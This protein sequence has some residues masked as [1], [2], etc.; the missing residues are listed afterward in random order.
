MYLNRIK[1]KLFPS[2][3]VFI[4]NHSVFFSPLPVSFICKYKAWGF[5]FPPFLGN[6]FVYFICLQCA[7][8]CGGYPLLSNGILY[9]DQCL[10]YLLL[11]FFFINAIYALLPNSSPIIFFHNKDNK[12]I[13]KTNLSF[14]L[15]FCRSTLCTNTGI[16]FSVH[17]P[18][19]CVC[20]MFTS[21]H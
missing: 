13:I 14:D 4:A 10:V 15:F 16:H 8:I 9:H 19:H 18:V 17:I 11:F 20:M 12:E 21:R 1:K 7:R 2:K 6:T 3:C 5:R